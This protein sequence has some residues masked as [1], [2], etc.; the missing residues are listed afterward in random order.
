MATPSSILAWRIPRTENPGRLQSSGLQRVER[1]RVTK[2][3]TAHILKMLDFILY[4][5]CLD[6]IEF[7]KTHLSQRVEH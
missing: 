6:K 5:L 4:K 1:D 7:I 2:H 3:S